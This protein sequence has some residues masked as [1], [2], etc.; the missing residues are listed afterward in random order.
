MKLFFTAAPQAR[1]RYMQACATVFAMKFIHTADIHLGA[2][3]D[4]GMP[5]SNTRSREIWDA[6][7]EICKEAGRTHT[8]LLLVAGDLFHRTPT[9]AELREVN[10]LFAMIPRTQVVLIAGNHDYVTQ[11]CP[12]QTFRW[13]ENVT[14]LFSGQPQRQ[15]F[16]QLRTAVYG[17][18]YTKAEY[19]EPLYDNLRPQQDGFTHILLGHGGDAKH[20]PVNPQRILSNGF[21]YV[22]LGHIHRPARLAGD[23]AWQCGSPAALDCSETGVHGYVAGEAAGGRVRTRFVPLRGREYRV[24]EVRCSAEDTTFSVQER[25]RAMIQQAP[26]HIYRLVLTGEHPAGAGFD[27]SAF[28]SLGM[29]LDT[30]DHTVARLDLK[31]LKQQYADGIIGRYISRF[32]GKAPGELEEKALYFGLE[33]LLSA[34]EDGREL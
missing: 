16:P 11:G 28:S 7:R 26:Q 2:A 22:A 6:F 23:A 3:P 27:P 18:S 9:V 15:V 31:K 20:S 12:Y 14:G 25:A 4:R 21:D 32:E 8:D 30:Q 24:L 1:C 5:W 33:A 17:C 34:S 10:A 13:N 19:T 29:V